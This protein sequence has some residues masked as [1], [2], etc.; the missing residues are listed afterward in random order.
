MAKSFDLATS[1]S[2][3][4]RRANQLA[5]DFYD[6]EDEADGLTQRQLA[7]LHA[8]DQN[9]GMNQTDLVKLTGIDRSTLADMIMRMQKRELLMRKR[10][11]EDGRANAVHMTTIGRRALRAS[12]PAM[13]KA[14]AALLEALPARVRGE[15]IKCLTALAA[16]HSERLADDQDGKKKRRPKR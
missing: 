4:L 12:M 13:I 2:H 1:P 15:F 14:D 8:V 10:T 3:L 7:V 11:E 9:D 16:T 6:D 5:T